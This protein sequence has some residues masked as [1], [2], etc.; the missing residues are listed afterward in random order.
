M[1]NLKQTITKPILKVSILTMVVLVCF[2]SF[3][4]NFVI[5]PKVDD[6]I[7][8]VLESKKTEIDIFFNTKIA[9]LEKVSLMI[10]QDKSINSNLEQLEQFKKLIDGYVSLGIIDNHGDILLTSGISFNVNNRD[11]YQTIKKSNDDVIISNLINSKETDEKIVVILLKMDNQ[12]YLSCA[13]NIDY[14]QQIIQTTNTF[15]FPVQII[16]NNTQQIVLQTATENKHNVVYKTNLDSKKNWELKIL[17][18]SSFFNNQIIMMNVSIIIITIFMF[19]L[20][21]YIIGYS[22]GKTIKP[23]ETLSTIMDDNGTYNLAN[24]KIDS[25]VKEVKN[26]VNS[27]NNMINEIEVLIKRIEAEEKSRKNSDYQALMEQIKPHFLYNTLETIQTMTLDY[28]DCKAE[29]AIGLLAKYF[30][31]SLSGDSE[32]ITIKQE[33]DMINYYIL[34]QKLRY[35]DKLEINIDSNIN[36]EQ[37][38]ILRFSLQ[39]IIEN[40]IC[41]G[42]NYVENSGL[43]NI[44]IIENNNQIIITISNECVSGDKVQIKNINQSLKSNDY[45]EKHGLFNVYQRHKLYFL[46]DPLNIELVNNQVIVR[47]NLIKIDG[48]NYEYFNL[49]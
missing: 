13:I 8:S 40:A 36:L 47:I 17:V 41:H 4:L 33:L 45:L 34:L 20:L 29:D 26:L 12:R 27:Y 48:E 3:L 49:R 14:I 6:L 38:Y 24:I 35:G 32:L 25:D 37:Y 7:N 15:S 2:S 43:I 21:K 1:K 28:D 31:L 39:P 30:R 9:E 19:L 5:K 11:Y 44:S 23:I 10:S 16:D 18:P 22:I 42:V 46:N